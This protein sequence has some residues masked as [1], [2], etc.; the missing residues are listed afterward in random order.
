MK[1]QFSLYRRNGIY[2]CEDSKTGKQESLR[3]RDEAAAKAML[4]SKNEAYR[5]PILNQ[6]IAVVY[7][8]AT[9]PEAATRAWRFVMDEMTATKRDETRYRYET[10]WADEAFDLIRDLPLLDTRADH[11]LKVLRTG[12]VSTNVYLRRLHNF[13]LDMSWLPKALLP[14]KQWPKPVFKEKRAITAGEH[15]AIIEREKNIE[16]RGFYQL[17]WHLGAAQTDLARLKAED[18]DW[19][20]KIISFFRLKTKTVCRLHFGEDVAEVL[21]DLPSTGYLFP[22]LATVRASDRATEFKQRCRGLQI[23]GV[24][25]HSYRYAWAERA[26]T[27]GYPERFAQE[28]LGHNSKAVH[29][30]YAKRAQVLLPPLEDYEKK[31][32]NSAPQ[33]TTSA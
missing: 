29:R 32:V 23:K 26:K 28:A 3:T 1:P 11:F 13:A 25:L 18:V 15:A 30:T 21:R 27:A 2:Y 6:S 20:Q 10:A 31:K 19:E 22:Y 14:R 4:H 16:R 12:T 9:D 17:A 33:P 5:Q 7:L 8:S 24:T